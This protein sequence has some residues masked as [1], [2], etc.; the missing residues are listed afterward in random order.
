MFWSSSMTNTTGRSSCRLWYTLPS[1]CR[2]SMLV[3]NS[4]PTLERAASIAAMVFGMISDRTTVVSI[5]ISNWLP[6]V[7]VFFP[8]RIFW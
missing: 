8:E 1:Y 4:A 5:R 7:L 3:S 2:G 6:N